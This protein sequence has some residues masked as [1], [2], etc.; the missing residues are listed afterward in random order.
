MDLLVICP[1]GKGGKDEI[2]YMNKKVATG[3]LDVD[4]N[5]DDE[6]Y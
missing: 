5:A 6:A 4:M 3:V 1:D 2:S